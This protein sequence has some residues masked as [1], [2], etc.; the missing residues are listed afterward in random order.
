[1]DQL[2]RDPAQYHLVGSRT[3]LGGTC[4]RAS[5]GEPRTE[6]LTTGLDEVPGDLGQQVVIGFDGLT[7]LIV[8]ASQIC[9]HGVQLEERVLGTRAV[10]HG[11]QGSSTG[12]PV[13]NRRDT[14]W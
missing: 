1:M 3:H 7:Q 4:R 9:R 2:H 12:R 11:P 8:N 5:D 13:K 6:A 10:G 14:C